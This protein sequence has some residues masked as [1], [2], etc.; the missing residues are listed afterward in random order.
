MKIYRNGVEIEL[1][2]H[3]LQ[4]AYE[5]RQHFHDTVDISSVADWYESEDEFVENFG[6]SF[7]V[8]E[9][10][11]DACAVRY[12]KYMDR[13]DWLYNAEEAIKDI[14]RERGLAE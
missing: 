3:E 5:E 7:A 6:I 1:T 14:V 2:S 4:A 11:E 8:L 9:D 13:A 12:R 10:I